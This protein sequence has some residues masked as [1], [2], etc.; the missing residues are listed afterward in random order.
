MDYYSE[1]R[2]SNS[3]RTARVGLYS[4]GVNILLVCLKLF[5]AALSGSLA[6]AA[7]AVHSAVDVVASLVVLVGLFISGRRSRL[8]PYGLYKVENLASVTLALLIFLAAYEI[9]R[10]AL[11]EP[12]R[13]IANAPLTL[14]G[15]VLAVLVAF[16][17]SRYER[18]IGEQTG[19]PSLIADSQHFRIDMLSS[20][21]VFAA[22]LGSA[23]QLPLDQLG[24]A[25]VVLFVV[26]AGW[27]LLVDG[28]RVLLDASLDHEM[29]D[30]IR[31]VIAA[32]PGIAE[33]RSLAGRN[34]GR[35][36]FI[37]TEV[38]LRTRNLEKA[39]QISQRLER[40]I[41]ESISRVDRVLVHYEPTQKEVLK[42]A[43]PLASLDGA[44]SPHFGEAP[45]FAL[46]QFKAATGEV[47]GREVLANP[48]T[49]VE[50]QKGI[51]V[52]EFLIGQ[53][54]DG[55]VLRESLEGKGPSYALADAGIEVVL[56]E[57]EKIG[58]I[59]ADL[60]AALTRREVPE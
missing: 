24:A 11:L 18:R 14:A 44:V 46:I 60:Q 32:D 51:K 19:S 37:E 57:K 58:G 34:S 42:W 21:V 53:G 25:V 56:T 28:M 8:F 13:E 1:D 50:K 5:L 29:L 23:L 22:V 6:L 43:A 16:L 31:R 4:V 36:K 15:V 12:R 7:D 33:I 35:Y 55:L 27:G 9:A 47:V 3:S 2:Q 41:R 49:A 59:L 30:Q 52:A 48:Y 10:E 54:V 26:W 40:A 17:F 38:S 39:H 20:G 45:Y